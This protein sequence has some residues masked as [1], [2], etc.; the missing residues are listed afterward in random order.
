MEVDVAARLAGV[1]AIRSYRYILIAQLCSI[2]ATSLAAI[3]LYLRSFEISGWSSGATLGFAIAVRMAI[4]NL[5]GMVAPRLVQGIPPRP[6]FLFSAGLLV[7]IIA[8]PLVLESAWQLV[9]AM[10]LL[11]LAATAFGMAFR[12]TVPLVVGNNEDLKASSDILQLATNLE[13]AV[14]PSI[15]A[16]L[17]GLVGFDALVGLAAA[18][19]VASAALI[20]FARL[21]AEMMPPRGVGH[22]AKGLARSG[23]LRTRSFRGMIALNIVLVAA[24]SMVL[25]NTPVLT[26][27]AFNRGEVFVAI[28]LAVFGIGSLGGLILAP[29]LSARIPGSAVMLFGA[30]LVS[31]SLFIGTLADAF[32]GV[33]VLW[34]ALGAGCSLSQVP[35]SQ[36][37]QQQKSPADRIA[38]RRGVI[39]SSGLCWLI[40]APIAGML[41][42][43]TNLSF[44]FAVLGLLSV[45]ATFAAAGSVA[46]Q[47]SRS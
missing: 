23:L 31:A 10:V 4:S 41:G 34:F 1:F 35:L 17:L 44:T 26:L 2:F 18:A 32:G 19:T 8:S 28:A 20:I 39:A 9:G 27:G 14:T 38:L 46:M 3:S 6:L 5:G 16:L 7:L 33:I 15:A 36:Y 25:V 12:G 42:A 45:L 21:P 30:A 24:S 11:E 29:R 43:G 13:P 40:V 37:I 22:P 47:I